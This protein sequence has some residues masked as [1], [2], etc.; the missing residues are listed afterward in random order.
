ML[1]KD[2]NRIV[3]SSLDWAH[4]IGDT[5]SYNSQ[6]HQKLPFDGFGLLNGIPIY[7]ECKWLPRAMSFNLN[8]IENHQIENL[9]KI[10]CL[11]PQVYCVIIL[12]VEWGKSDRRA[13]I[14]FNIEEIAKR[15]LEGKHYLKKELEGLPHYKI[16]SNKVVDIHN[17]SSFI[18]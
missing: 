3:C 18:T 1:E 12:G 9:Q 5:V 11:N 10:H 13:Y 15:R 2:L 17:T 7:F 8:R 16:K 4:K 6:V 14:F